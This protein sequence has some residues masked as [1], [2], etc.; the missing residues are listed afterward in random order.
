MLFKRILGNQI[1]T[2]FY[3]ESDNDSIHIV[4]GEDIRLVTI[5]ASY[6]GG[7]NVL[8]WLP[9]TTAN[10]ANKTDLVTVVRTGEAA[11]R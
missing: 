10:N 11:S 7:D 3:N 1:A 4:V 6:P 2:L 9:D 8:T 5:S